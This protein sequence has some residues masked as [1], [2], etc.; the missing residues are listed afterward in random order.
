MP[1]VSNRAAS[2][3]LT[4]P[5][6]PFQNEPVTS[7]QLI[8]LSLDDLCL[9]AER[10]GLDLPPGLERSFVVEEILNALDE[11]VDERRSAGAGAIRIQ[12]L[13]YSGSE[14][15]ALRAPNQDPPVLER[16]YNETNLQAL[17]R[18]PS[19]AFAFWDISDA[20]RAKLQDGESSAE[21]F[22]RITETGA[23]AAKRQFFDIPVSYDDIQWYVNLPR[24]SARFRI[25]LCARR[26]SGRLRVLARSCEIAA[27]RQSRPIGA[28]TDARSSALL[29]LSGIEALNV[30]PRAEAGAEANPLRILDDSGGGPIAPA[31]Q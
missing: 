18:D 13:K 7:E 1:P 2:S 31:G 11:D 3:P 22:L 20:D 17:V 27:P 26:P 29:K 4:R 16:R 25:E 15:D 14:P 6:G 8:S 23:E 9:L 21:L 12:E 19:W 24:P 30:E 28:K 10:M 5:S